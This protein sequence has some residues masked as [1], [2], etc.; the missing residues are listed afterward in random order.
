MAPSQF[1]LHWRSSE[2]SS[3]VEVFLIPADNMADLYA[4]QL[5]DLLSSLALVW[6]ACLS[7]TVACENKKKI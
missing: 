2:V 1:V 5:Q 7:I 3:S 4:A 6:Q